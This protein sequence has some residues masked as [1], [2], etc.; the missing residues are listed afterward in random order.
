MQPCVKLDPTAFVADRE[1]IEALEKRSTPV[2]CAE[3][4]VLFTQGDAAHGLYI[5]H[6]GD[7]F[8][9]MAGPKGEPILCMQPFN[10]SLLGLPALIGNEPYSLTA[11]ALK[12]AE[13]SYVKRDDFQKLL[14]DEPQLPM[15]ILHVLAAEVRAARL[16]LL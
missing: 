7:A 6:G 11:K 2:T 9:T 3:D 1:L 15:R 5:L 14:E 13:F 10:G 8:L 12:G 16:A 4:S